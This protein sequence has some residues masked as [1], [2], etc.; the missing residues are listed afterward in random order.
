MNA[1]M[2]V[3]NIQL[4]S[5]DPNPNQPRKHFDPDLLQELADSIACDGLI[6]PIVLRRSTPTDR[7]MIVDGERRWRASQLAGLTDVPAVIHEKLSDKDMQV[8]SLVANL[9]RSDLTFWEE[10]AACAQLVETIGLGETAKR[11]AKKSKSWVSRRASVATMPEDIR[12]LA[13]DGLVRDQEILHD[14]KKVRELNAQT[15]VYLIRQIR[16]PESHAPA[17]TREHLRETVQQLERL[18]R[19]PEKAESGTASPKTEMVPKQGSATTVTVPPVAARA[20]A[21]ALSKVDQCRAELTALAHDLA[22]AISPGAGATGTCEA[23][24]PA[25]GNL[26]E[27]LTLMLVLPIADVEKTIA[28]LARSRDAEQLSPSTAIK[29]KPD[30]KVDPE[31]EKGLSLFI[32]RRVTKQAGS[33]VKADEFYSAYASFCKARKAPALPSNSSTL[34]Y[35]IEQSG[36]K[37]HRSTQGRSYLAIKLSRVDK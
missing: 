1:S 6:Q 23:F 7:Y 34:A 15:G 16:N 12:A 37:K 3:M 9:Q 18:S 17:V 36:I 11:I 30:R 2:S 32:Q 24:T 10:C 26:R 28:T 25:Y 8:I 29:Q 22:Q 21:A 14:L 20:A 5:I 27:V 31:T 35:L 33:V 19:P 13:Q 4:T